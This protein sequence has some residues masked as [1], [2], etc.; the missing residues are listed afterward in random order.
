MYLL[1]PALALSCFADEVKLKNGDRLTGTVTRLDDKELTLKTEYAGD[2]KI[3]RDAIQ[4]IETADALSVSL[5]DGQNLM[6]RLKLGEGKV[7]VASETTGVIAAKEAD[8]TLFRSKAD[9]EAYAKEIERMKNP[10]LVDLWTGAVDLGYAQA[11]GNA[12]TNTINSSARVL[13]T[14]TRDSINAYFLSLY[15]KNT[16]NGLSV[17]AA[18]SIRG[19][20]KYDL[21][22][23]PKMYT[24]G[25]TDLEF[26]EFQRLDL[27]FVPAGG[28][29]YHWIK[30]KNTMWDLF[31]GG[32]L[33][34]EFFASG[35]KR[36]SGEVLMGN[37]L[38]HKFAG[39]FTFSEKIV[40]Y[41]N[42]TSSGNYRL[43]TDVAFAAAIKKW[44]SYQVT[45]SN[46]YL[47][48]PLP[49]RKT[50]DL[51]ITTGVRLVFNR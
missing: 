18:N 31:G 46:R 35:L 9:Q 40:F 15:S 20:L 1:S 14:T 34:R 5:K 27:R 8:V 36:N 11:R 22:I 4:S 43:N 47:S 25:S 37:E 23:T 38:S 7:E 48:N 49:G 24:F 12:Q 10:R 6:G 13:R 16:N 17:L 50:N 41:N 44:L 45:A 19:G 32:S 33:N 51:V 28:L 30:N 21:N 29:G 26:D 3:K 42:V 2:L 39:V